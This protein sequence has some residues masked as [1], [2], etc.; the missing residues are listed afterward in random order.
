MSTPGAAPVRAAGPP[1]PPAPGDAGIRLLAV[2]AHPDDE[3]LATG[4]ALAHHRMQG[5][6][7]HV[8]T[9][10]L[11][12]EG[13]VI[14][15]ELAHLEGSPE[16]AAHRHTELMGAMQTLGVQHHYLGGA[17][18]RWRD[19]GMAGSTAAGHPNAFAGADVTEAAEVLTEQLRSLGPDVVLTYDP[20]GG[21]G[22]P[23]HIQTHRVT[24]A[25][26]ASLAPPE[27]PA[28]YVVLTPRSWAAENRRWLAQHVPAAAP[29]TVPGPHE[30]YPPSV[31]PD[32]QVGHRLHAPPAVGLR[33][34]ALRHHR[35]QVSVYD[36]YYA[37]SN[38][39]AARLP[40]R[41]GYSRWR[42]EH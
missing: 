21:Y 42:H 26:V 11:G 28:L 30:P 33:D 12:E 36:G 35:T 16:L 39:I 13:E 8:I 2:H 22:H 6:E 38:D 14:P 9:A 17:R 7:V 31:V 29:V 1:A 32:E 4:V 18:P 27:R 19:S 40:D 20:Q 25:A 37:L 34:E 3:T 23:D 5:D 10:T 41:E 15:R 24:V